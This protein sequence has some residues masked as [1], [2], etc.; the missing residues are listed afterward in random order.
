MI[1]QSNLLLTEP[2][3]EKN[4]WTQKG[5]FADNVLKNPARCMYVFMCMCGCMYLSCMCDS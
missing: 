4:C 2:I 1:L 5:P 3:A